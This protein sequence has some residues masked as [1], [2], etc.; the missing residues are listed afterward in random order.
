MARPELTI[1]SRWKCC[2]SAISWSTRK[3]ATCNPRLITKERTVQQK[4][5]RLTLHL[6]SSASRTLMRTQMALDFSSACWH[7]GDGRSNWRSPHRASNVAVGLP[8]WFHGISISIPIHIFV[9][10][11]LLRYLPGCI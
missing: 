9:E 3:A 11:K 8:N 1:R 4:H 10:K 5:F 2:I 7:I 6:K